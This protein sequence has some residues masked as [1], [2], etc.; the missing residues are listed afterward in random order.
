MTGSVVEVFCP[1]GYGRCAGVRGRRPAGRGLPFVA[2]DLTADPVAA[3]RV[4]DLGLAP[5][6]VLLTADGRAASDPAALT[7]PCRC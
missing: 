3:Q 4:G 6:P 2:H 7:A 1:A 5:L